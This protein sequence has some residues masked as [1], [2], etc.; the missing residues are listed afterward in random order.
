MNFPAR[1]IFTMEDNLPLMENAAIS[2]DKSGT[3]KIKELRTLDSAAKKRMI[4]PF[5]V[6][7]H[8]HL[9]LSLFRDKI[10]S[11]FSFNNWLK[12]LVELKNQAAPG[13]ILSEMKNALNESWQLGTGVLFDVCND[14]SLWGEIEA[15]DERQEL[16]LFYE[17]LGFDPQNAGDTY[18]RAKNNIE[19]FR[20]SS[21]L[22][23]Y[24]TPHSLYS[25]STELL[26]KIKSK[27]NSPISIHIAEHNAEI[28]MFENRSGEMVAYLKSMK[29]WDNNW[30]PPKKGLIPSAQHLNIPARGDLAV[31]LVK[32][33]DED[34]KAL[35]IDGVT[36]CLC[37]RSND[38]YNNGQ[39]PVAKMLNIGMKP[40]L[41]TDSLASNSTLNMVDE[42]R[43]ALNNWLDVPPLDV[44]KMATVNVSDFNKKRNYEKYFP[45]RDGGENP[46]LEIIFEN[47]IADPF[48][49]LKSNR[50]LEQN[51]H[52]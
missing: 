32:A 11:G 48:E 50:I 24:L 31:H 9:E 10:E 35:A 49:S 42:I 39:P 37:P 19:L 6:N 21:P 28:E 52:A 40:L 17:L 5:L 36:P 33:H 20:K 51:I 1:W 22:E 4:L 45:L 16:L 2:V 30:Q 23:V 44:I 3:I 25:C 34:L 15:A 13:Q 43:F 14:L 27:N 38:Y 12:M 29:L 47:D 8:T 26:K 41:G 7:A 18:K 46:F